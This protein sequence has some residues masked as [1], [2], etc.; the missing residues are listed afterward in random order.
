LGLLA[1]YGTANAVLKST[2]GGSNWTGYS[3][4]LPTT[5]ENGIFVSSLIADPTGHLRLFVSIA[6]HGLYRS[7][8]GAKNWKKLWSPQNESIISLVAEPSGILY[9][10]TIDHNYHRLDS[11]AGGTIYKSADGGLNWKIVNNGLPNSAV[12]EILPDPRSNQT[13]YIRTRKGLYRTTDSGNSWQSFNSGLPRH[14]I[15]DLDVL[16]TNPPGI[17]VGTEVGLYEKALE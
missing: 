16:Q 4:G 2:D 9:A 17:L 8:D 11:E 7:N 13:V 1:E 3:K 10:G 6:R 14:N 12:D 5:G 15:N